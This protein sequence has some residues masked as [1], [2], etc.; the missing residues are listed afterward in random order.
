M[1]ADKKNIACIGLGRM[2]TP[3]AVNILQAGYEASVYDVRAQMMQPLVGLGARPATSPKDAAAAADI[4]TLVVVDD[5]QVEAVLLG[6]DG[7]FASA[8]PGTI[9]AI[10]ST[11]LPQ[12]VRRLAQL[13]QERGVHVIDAPVSGGEAG[14]RDKQLCYMIGGDAALLDTCRPLFETS[15]AEIFHMGPLGAGAAAKALVQIVTCINMLAA[16]EAEVMAAENG[17]DFA[18]VQKML[19]KSAAQSFVV[20]NWLHRFKLADDPMAVR[21]R[22]VEVFQKSLGPA[23]E[24]ARELGVELDGSALAQ[25]L[26]PQI[27]GIAK[28]A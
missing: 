22:R 15:A 10:H 19:S 1:G 6:S 8:R 26:M 18:M 5:A 7:V 25:R 9:V 28:K 21:Q 24:L 13:G 11:V 20:A 27:M 14:V 16:H 12:T 2:G 3:M 23:L 4:V 17:L